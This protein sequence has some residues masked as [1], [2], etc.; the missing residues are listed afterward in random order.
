MVN[1]ALGIGSLLAV[2]GLAMIVNSK[3]YSRMYKEISKGIYPLYLGAFMAFLFGLFVLAFNSE[4]G[5]KFTALQ[6]IGW[7]SVVKG[8]VIFLLPGVA[9]ALARIREGRAILVVWGVVALA[10]GLLLALL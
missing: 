8:S 6:V 5:W 2:L 9:K 3:S 7:L 1:L 4:A 10:V